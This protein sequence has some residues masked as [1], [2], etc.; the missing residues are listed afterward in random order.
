MPKCPRT[1]IH[2]GHS[3]LLSP[4]RKPIVG[5]LEIEMLTAALCSNVVIGQV[6]G[7]PEKKQKD[8]IATL[9]FGLWGKPIC[10]AESFIR[11]T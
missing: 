11:K 8:L 6:N 5:N 3:K 4:G 7:D 9:E 10:S 2:G 1:L